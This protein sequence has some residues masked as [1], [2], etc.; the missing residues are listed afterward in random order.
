ME[1][2]LSRVTGP[3][4]SITSNLSSALTHAVSLILGLSTSFHWEKGPSVPRL[5]FAVSPTDAGVLQDPNQ[6]PFLPVQ[7]LTGCVPSFLWL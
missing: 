1:E 6:F 5:L 4:A 7:I 3:G 2:G